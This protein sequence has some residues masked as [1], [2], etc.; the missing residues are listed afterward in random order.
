MIILNYPVSRVNVAAT[1]LAVHIAQSRGGGGGGGEGG[2]EGGEGGEG[3]GETF[4]EVL[5][6]RICLTIKSSINW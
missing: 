2:G 6:R 4:P 3:G 5:T 1:D